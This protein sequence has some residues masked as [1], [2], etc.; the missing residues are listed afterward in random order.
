MW[1]FCII[2]YATYKLLILTF[3]TG[4]TFLTDDILIEKIATQYVTII[5]R[6]LSVLL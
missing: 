6:I 5:K 3:Y 2:T 1:R 4:L